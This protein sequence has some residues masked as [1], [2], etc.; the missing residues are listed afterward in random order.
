MLSSD[1]IVH[2]LKQ[3]QDLIARRNVL[4]SG[5]NCPQW[6]TQPTVE[7]NEFKSWNLGFTVLTSLK[8]TIFLRRVVLVVGDRSTHDSGTDLW[9]QVEC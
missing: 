1:G 2:N 3:Q 6:K 5:I 8:I 7:W 9:D 4:G